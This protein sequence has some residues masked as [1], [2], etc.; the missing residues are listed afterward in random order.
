MHCDANQLGWVICMIRTCRQPPNGQPK[1]YQPPGGWLVTTYFCMVKLGRQQMI[2]RHACCFMLVVFQNAL[3]EIQ[4]SWI[5][6]GIKTTFFDHSTRYKPCK[7]MLKHVKPYL[8]A[9]H[10]PISQGKLVSFSGSP[11]APQDLLRLS[12]GRSVGRLLGQAGDRAQGP[13]ERAG[14]RRVIHLMSECSIVNHPAIG[15]PP[16]METSMYEDVSLLEDVRKPV[17]DSNGI[18]W[19]G[20]SSSVFKEICF[21]HPRIGDHI[22]MAWGDFTPL[23]VET[24]RNLAWAYWIYRFIL[25]SNIGGSWIYSPDWIQWFFHILPMSDRQRVPYVLIFCFSSHC[26]EQIYTPAN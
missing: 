24:C 22:G 21:G 2:R 11:L 10:L 1:P 7:T 26:S 17:M 15:L 12:K 13:I 19:F 20:R 25:E 3:A 6:F 16:F 23:Y 4:I 9:A 8:F 18:Y 14:R 5:F